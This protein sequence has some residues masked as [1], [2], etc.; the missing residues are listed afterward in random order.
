M[1]EQVQ[2]ILAETADR[3]EKKL[4]D[5]AKLKEYTDHLEQIITVFDERMAELQDEY[6][7]KR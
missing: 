2:G 6:A 5:D 3:A 1:T 7:E 4:I